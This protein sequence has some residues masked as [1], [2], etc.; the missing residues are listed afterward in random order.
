MDWKGRQGGSEG[1]EGIGGSG[2][3]IR[4]KTC[5]CYPDPFPPTET[6][7]RSQISV[8]QYHEP[9]D[10]VTVLGGTLAI[11]QVCRDISA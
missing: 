8:R 10:M 5:R 1:G 3:E 11:R 4:D 2:E 7:V 6:E 9:T